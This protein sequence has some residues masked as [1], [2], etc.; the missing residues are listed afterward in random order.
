MTFSPFV[1]EITS[2]AELTVEVGQERQFSF[3]II[4][5][6]AR[7][8]IHE[9]ALYALLVDQEGEGHEA[10]WLL[11]SPSR[12]LSI[13]AGSTETVTITVRPTTDSP[14]GR[15]TIALAIVD[16]GRSENAYEDSPFVT[17]EIVAPSAPIEAI[18]TEVVQDEDVAIENALA[19]FES[20]PA[21]SSQVAG[22]SAEIARS[23]SPPAHG[24]ARIED[25]PASSP[26]DAE[27]VPT[28]IERD[29]GFANETAQDMVESSL[30]E[31][32]QT[33][34]AP[35]ERSPTES[36]QAEDSPADSPVVEDT[37]AE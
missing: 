18:P 33:S 35:A 3:S 11:V 1:I 12:D 30:A 7:G 19:A 17:C 5:P 37:P 13:R 24:S 26:L 10:D 28:E 4:A 6:P 22:S 2:A 20:S 25:V 9:V 16:K 23:A 29:E 27:R 32:S 14:Q 31:S 8:K 34:G 15:H 21:E 36:T